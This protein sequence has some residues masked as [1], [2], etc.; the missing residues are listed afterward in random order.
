MSMEMK[1]KMMKKS[2]NAINKLHSLSIHIDEDIVKFMLRPEASRCSAR[3]HR[4]QR[5]GGVVLKPVSAGGASK[6][7]SQLSPMEM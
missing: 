4:S 6:R 3:E 1:K 2:M 7:R 5:T